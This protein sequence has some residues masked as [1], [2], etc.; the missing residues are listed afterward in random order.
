LAIREGLAASALH[1]NSHAQIE[2]AN[3]F[4]D[5]ARLKFARDSGFHGEIKRRVSDYFRRT[6]LSPR[7]NSRMYEK[8]AV[9]LVWF[10][11]SY[12]CL[13]FAATTWWQGA[14]CSVSLALATAGVGFG[15][16]HDANHGA[17]SSH[18]AVNRLMGMTLDMLGASSYLWRFKH[19]LSHHTYTN[20][21][22]A[23]DDIDIGPLGRLS[24]AQP[25]RSL[26]RLQHVYLWLLYGLLLHKWHLVYDFKNVARARIADNRFPRPRGWSLAE[27]IGGKLLFFG[28]ALVLPALY[29]RWWIV[30]LYYAGTAFVIGVVLS[31]V[32]QLAHCV[33]EADFPERLPETDRL[34]EGWAVHQVQTTVDFARANRFLTWYLGGLNFQ[35]EHHLFPRVCHVHYPRIADIVQKASAEFGVRYTAHEGL[36]RAVSSHWRWLRRMGRPPGPFHEEPAEVGGA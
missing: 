33:E 27:L 15:I 34:S 17:Y 29:H 30:L 35:I 24:P 14:L 36:F 10:A 19:N 28:W 21:A 13:V 6:G 5:G 31:V 2:T 7:D 32:F 26:H 12:A 11:A 22:G 8:S 20:V 25:H 23:D 9:L 4:G 18:R 1:L 16:Q 3:P